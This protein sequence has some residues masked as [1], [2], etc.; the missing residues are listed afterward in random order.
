M[1]LSLGDKVQYIY[2]NGEFITAIKYN[3]YKVNL[4]LLEGDYFEVFIGHRIVEIT[5]VSPL[6][7]KS[8]RI[9]LYLDQVKIT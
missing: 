5:N 6:N 2:E 7:Y 1:D 3:E 4:F 8:S 9:Y